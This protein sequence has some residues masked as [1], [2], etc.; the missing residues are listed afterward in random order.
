VSTNP[1]F[2]AHYRE[3]D[4]ATQSLAD[5]LRAVAAQ[6]SCFAEKIG[7]VRQG[8]LIGLLHDVGKYSDE[9]QAY[10]KSAVGLLNQDD[11]EEFVDAKGLKGKVD[12]STAGAQLAYTELAKHGQLGEIVGKALALFRLCQIRSWSSR[13]ACSI[14]CM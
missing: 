7:L 8:E 14:Q 11:D 5:H 12:H 6:A 10:L 1:A 3:A 4:R 13:F 2:I 9:F